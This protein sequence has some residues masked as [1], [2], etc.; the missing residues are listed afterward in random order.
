VFS[1]ETK[2]TYSADLEHRRGWFFL[3][4]LLIAGGLFA[5]VLMVPLSLGDDEVDA[6]LLESIVQDMEFKPDRP[7]D[8]M[9]AYEAPK[10]KTPEVKAKINVV[11]EAPLQEIPERLVKSQESQLDGEGA[12]KDSADQA[13]ALSP[14]AVDNKDNPLNFRVVERLPEFPGGSVEFMKWLTRNLKYP[15]S[16]RQ[17][18]VQ[19]KV[20]VSFVINADGKTSDVKVL[21]KV[22]PL[23]DR[24]ALRVIR[25][26]P[27]WKPGE[28]KGKPCSTMIAI[29]VVFAL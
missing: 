22:H 27:E 6:E 24:E 21:T 3:I 18:K 26:M 23:L 11:E 8:N 2:K 16:A 13:K 4:G 10:P 15:E 5:L 19:G 9:I 12:V 25:M 17:Q 28:D 7:A 29:P 1:V 14:V 20:V